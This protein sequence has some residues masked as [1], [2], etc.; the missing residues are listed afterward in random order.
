[1]GE[2]KTGHD[3]IEDKERAVVVCDLPQSFEI[4]LLGRNA[5]HVP[6]DGFQDD[7]GELLSFA[8]EEIP[9]RPEVVVRQD[10]CVPCGTSCD[11]GAVRKAEGCN[12]RAGRDEEGVAVTVVVAVELENPLSSRI[13]AGEPDGAHRRLRSGVGHPDHLDGRYGSTHELRELDFELRRGAEGRTFPRR[14]LY[15][16]DDLRIRMPEDEG[17]VAHHVVEIR[18]AVHI[19]DARTLAAIHKQRVSTDR[20]ECPHGAVYAAGHEP[21]GP[22]HQPGRAVHGKLCSRVYALSATL[23]TRQPPSLRLFEV[24]NPVPAPAVTGLTPSGESAGCPHLLSA[25]LVQAKPAEDEQSS[26]GHKDCAHYGPEHL[27]G[28]EATGQYAD[29]LQQPDAAYEHHQPSHDQQHVAHTIPPVPNPGLRPC[30]VQ[31]SHEV[32]GRWKPEPPECAGCSPSG[33]RPRD[34]PAA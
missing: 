20:A 22:F 24:Y 15:S 17:T 10:G 2:P 1:M 23:Q 31:R 16:L 29:A 3:F 19:E 12:T 34:P 5:P 33:R 4:A 18:V 26:N 14:G 30:A 7:G 6:C 21:D 25:A 32:R 13:S 11:A 27:A 9:D 8:R 28:H